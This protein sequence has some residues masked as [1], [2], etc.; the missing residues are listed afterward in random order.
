MNVF[1]LHRDPILAAQMQH[2]KHVVKMILETAQILSTVCAAAGRGAG[3]YKP[4]HQSHPCVVWAGES[5]ANFWWLYHHGLA[6]CDEYTHRFDKVHASRDVLL[7]C[8]ARTPHCDYD[9]RLVTPAQ[10]MPDEFKMPG[11]PVT[12]YRKYYL[13]RKISQSRWTRRPVPDVFK[14]EYEMSKKHVKL[15]VAS[16][17]A[18]ADAPVA[19]TATATTKI[20]V[21]GPKGV[22][23]DAT[24]TVLSSK[25]PK[26][27]ESKAHA[28]FAKYADGMTV[29]EFLD[30]AG[31]A[32]TPNLVYDVAHG[33]IAIAGYDPKMVVLKVR[34]AKVAKETKA[35]KE[36]LP[37]KEES[38]EQAELESAT[39]E[40]LID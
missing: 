12:A 31:E 29:Q 30:A 19:V 28:V 1:F 22:A 17:P 16:T 20:G 32:A 14:E 27:P 23:L 25:N 10:C 5:L 33:F 24:I 21:K 9:A 11:D 3:L 2:D 37:P 13:G 15:A 7:M 6:L 18:Q 8:A 4:T 40:E 26:R 36:K 39:Q 35:K 38:Q 34:A